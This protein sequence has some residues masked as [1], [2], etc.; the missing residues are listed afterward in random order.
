MG[1]KSMVTYRHRAYDWWTSWMPGKWNI[2]LAPLKVALDIQTRAPKIAAYYISTIEMGSLWQGKTYL[3]NAY[4]LL[5]RDWVNRWGLYLSKEVLWGS[6]CQRAAKLQAVK[7]GDLKKILPRVRM[8]TKRRQPGFESWMIRS[9]S[10]FAA[11]WST[12]THSTFL[13]WSWPRC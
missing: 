8:W 13:E 7:V 10:N 11:L 5:K 2:V 6:V 3:K 4:S 1:Q 12:E 9:S